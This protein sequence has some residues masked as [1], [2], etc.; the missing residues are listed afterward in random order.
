MSCSHLPC[1][2]GAAFGFMKTAVQ[3]QRARTEESSQVKQQS[4][5][6]A[7]TGFESP[8][9]RTDDAHEPAVR[10]LVVSVPMQLLEGIRRVDA[11]ELYESAWHNR[12][13]EARPFGVEGGIGGAPICV[14]SIT[15]GV[16][17]PPLRR[18]RLHGGEGGSLKHSH[19]LSACE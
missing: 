17:G 16:R 14:C 10:I 4:K 18:F 6:V 15:G 9:R 11:R 8:G 19:T 5:L 1:L 13:I 3:Q 2:A 7:S 12:E